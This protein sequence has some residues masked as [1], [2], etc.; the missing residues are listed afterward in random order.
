MPLFGLMDEMTFLAVF[1]IVRSFFI[2]WSITVFLY[3][4]AAYGFSLLFF[5]M[6]YKSININKIAVDSVLFAIANSI[7]LNVILSKLGF[8]RPDE[9]PLFPM[10]VALITI[11]CT[12]FWLAM[13]LVILF[14]N[15]KKPIPEG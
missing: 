1:K 10:I 2:A 14:H 15:K 4:I 13:F 8:F 9:F 3:I 6:Y 11:F 5:S 12:I 7:T